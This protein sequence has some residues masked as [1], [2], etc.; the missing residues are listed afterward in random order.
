MKAT[1]RQL[2]E[3]TEL[4][5]FFQSWFG[6]QW[7][8]KLRLRARTYP[9]HLDRVISGLENLGPTLL[10][11]LRQTKTD[12]LFNSACDVRLAAPPR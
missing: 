3:L 4:R 10:P 2:D 8:L 11:R 9:R 1:K 7:D 12:L 5:S 6:E